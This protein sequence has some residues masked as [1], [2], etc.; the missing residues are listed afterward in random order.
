MLNLEISLYFKIQHEQPT[1]KYYLYKT[2]LCRE[3][4]KFNKQINIKATLHRTCEGCYRIKKMLGMWN[5]SVRL[6]LFIIYFLLTNKKHIYKS[7]FFPKWKL[8]Y[9]LIQSY[10]YGYVHS[11]Q[12]IIFSLAAMAV[13]ATRIKVKIKMNNKIQNQQ[14]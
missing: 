6:W 7:I 2:V 5:T 14:T 4:P 8:Q 11:L 1:Q 9:T 10:S 3:M 12:F 13:V